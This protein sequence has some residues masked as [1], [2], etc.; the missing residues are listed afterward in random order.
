MG[1]RL[2][3]GWR[4]VATGVCFTVFG[5]TGV[6]LT[7]FACPLIFLLVHPAD[8]RK[9]VGQRLI[10]ASFA[11][12]VRFMRALGVLTYEIRGLERLERTGCVV[13][14][15]HPSL[16]DVVL[17]LAVMGRADCIVK[18]R[19]WKNPATGVPLRIA[20]YIR[21]TGGV[22][23][24]EQSCASLKEGNRLLVF[25]EGTRTRL[26]QPLRFHRGA[27]NIAVYAG[28][29]I[30]PVTIRLS[31]PT[32]AKHHPWYHIPHRR[33]HVTLSVDEPIPVEPFITRYNSK[34]LAARRLTEYMR[35]YY[36]QRLAKGMADPGDA[37]AAL[38]AG[39]SPS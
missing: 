27:A 22:G 38:A 17:L 20:G 35:G 9:R 26:G 1:S 33:L 16:I 2:D 39:T 11:G 21:N 5:V 34:S 7:I 37:G 32:L 18:D 25:P 3:Y 23:L 14:A 19:L 29:D 36:E 15:N 12:F 6:V 30:V 13:V 4:L 28:S 8:H 31:E 24:L 10:S